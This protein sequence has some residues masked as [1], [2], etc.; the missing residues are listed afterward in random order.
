MVRVTPTDGLRATATGAAMGVR[1]EEHVRA[2]GWIVASACREEG[3]G[4]SH[5]AKPTSTMSQHKVVH[6]LQCLHELPR[7]LQELITVAGP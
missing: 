6:Q 5:M 2:A 3:T 4:C 7:A 1:A